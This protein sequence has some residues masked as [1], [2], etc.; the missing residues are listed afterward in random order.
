M[1]WHRPPLDL[2]RYRCVRRYPPGTEIAEQRDEKRENS[3]K[4]FRTLN[5]KAATPAPGHDR[6]P[7]P[8]APYSNR[9]AGAFPDPGKDQEKESWLTSRTSLPRSPSSAPAPSSSP[10]ATRALPP[11]SPTRPTPLRRR[12]PKPPRLT[13]LWAMTCPETT[14]RTTPWAKTPKA[15][16]P[17][18]MRLQR[19][20]AP[21][22]ALSKAFHPPF[23]RG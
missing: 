23:N 7:K 1:R 6:H 9:R 4:N 13:T 17:K 15:K 20:K 3:Q 14:W 11:P 12:P 21:A 8:R 5:E 2:G 18:A 19:A 22:A 10:V 16:R